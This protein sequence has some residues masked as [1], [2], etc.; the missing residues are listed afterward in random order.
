[1]RPQIRPIL[2]IPIFW[3]TKKYRYILPDWIFISEGIWTWGGEERSII[4]HFREKTLAVAWM[5]YLRVLRLKADELES[6]AMVWWQM[7]TVWTK[8]MKVRMV[9]KQKFWNQFK[10]LNW[11]DLVINWLLGWITKERE[12]LEDSWGL[13]LCTV[14]VRNCLKLPV[15]FTRNNSG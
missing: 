9:R 6:A 4:S 10:K 5:I 11:Q 8:A 1:M 12:I 2:R 7:R 3:H 14:L 13:C 15:T